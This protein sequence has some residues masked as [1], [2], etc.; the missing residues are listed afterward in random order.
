[1]SLVLLSR[2][3]FATVVIVIVIVIVVA[4]VAAAPTAIA[5]HGCLLL[6]I[7]ANHPASIVTDA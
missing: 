6:A 5:A 7:A 3:E 2:L 1:M 4:V